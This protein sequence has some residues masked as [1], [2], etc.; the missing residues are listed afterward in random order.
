MHLDPGIQTFFLLV[1]WWILTPRHTGCCTSGPHSHSAIH[2]GLVT[3]Q[4]VTAAPHTACT[5]A[6]SACR[7]AGGWG[8]ELPGD[9]HRPCLT[10]DD[11]VC[12]SCT[13]GAHL[14]DTCTDGL[15]FL[16]HTLRVPQI[17]AFHGPLWFHLFLLHCLFGATLSYLHRS[18]VPALTFSPH[19]LISPRRIS[20]P[21]L[22]HLPHH[23][24]YGFVHVPLHTASLSHCTTPPVLYLASSAAP[25]SYAPLFA[26]LSHPLAVSVTDT[27]CTA[28]DLCTSHPRTS[29]SSPTLPWEH[30]LHSPLPYLC[31]TFDAVQFVAW[32]L[33]WSIQD[34]RQVRSAYLLVTHCGHFPLGSLHG[35][36]GAFPFLHHTALPSVCSLWFLHCTGTLRFRVHH[37]FVFLGSFTPFSLHEMGYPSALL[38]RSPL[39]PPP[40][41]YYHSALGYHAQ[42]HTT[43]CLLLTTAS[44]TTISAALPPLTGIW[45]A[46][47]LTA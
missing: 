20:A 2:H 42:V 45:V 15:F 25:A 10:L 36:T 26:C 24:F 37:L 27:G 23:H 13:G 29:T 12:T 19:I 14:G 40:L 17:G 18:Q 6:H 43:A 5:S 28:L 32:T 22:G 3:A 1:F 8:M 33:L 30:G 11:G 4:E 21:P 46:L 34:A 31:T 41:V 16:G 35:L 47:H 38:T 9:S 7:L 44:A 39:S